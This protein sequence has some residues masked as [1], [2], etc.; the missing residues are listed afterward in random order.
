MCDPNDDWPSK[1]DESPELTKSGMEILPNQIVEL[2]NRSLGS[3]EVDCG[4]TFPR[5]QP[6]SE[7]DDEVTEAKIRAFL[8]EKVYTDEIVFYMFSYT[9]TCPG[10][11]LV[12]QI[13]LVI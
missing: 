8:D 6:G 11:H 12:L 10:K 1:F 13:E 3:V 5:G 2:G 7:D 9:S 4:F